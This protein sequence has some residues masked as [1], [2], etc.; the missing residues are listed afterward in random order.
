MARILLGRDQSITIDGVV[1]EGTRELDVDIGTKTIDVTHWTHPVESTH[2]LSAAISIR[3]LIYWA[4]CY[5]KFA[6]RFNRH[7][8]RPFVLGITGAGSARVVPTNVTIKQPI[9]GVVAWE[10]TCR[11]YY[12]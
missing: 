5:E 2:V 4:E 6:A 9:T 8:P 1:A 7:P 11:P 3:V 12:L 10:V